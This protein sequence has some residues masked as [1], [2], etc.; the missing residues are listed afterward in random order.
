MLFIDKKRFLQNK[1]LC[2]K[3]T[4]DKASR[5]QKYEQSHYF[6]PIKTIKSTLNLLV[7][8]HIHDFSI[9]GP[10]H[11]TSAEFPQERP[12]KSKKSNRYQYPYPLTSRKPTNQPAMCIY[13]RV[14][15]TG[16]GHD[17]WLQ[18]A[19]PCRDEAC[20]TMYSHPLRTIKIHKRCKR[21]LDKTLRVDR[22]VETLKIKLGELK[23]TFERIRARSGGSR[24]SASTTVVDG[25]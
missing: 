15:F 11:N 19:R 24:T 18:L 13:D 25:N 1:R 12:K 10:T 6:D 21:C 2:S 23:E 16:C 3:N 17:Q 22:N 9:Q 4:T 5:M 20:E 8:P 14:L 7:L